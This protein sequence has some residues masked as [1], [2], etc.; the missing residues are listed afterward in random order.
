MEAVSKNNYAYFWTVT[1]VE[2]AIILKWIDLHKGHR[3][4]FFLSKKQSSCDIMVLRSRAFIYKPVAPVNL[5][6]QE[7]VLVPEQTEDVH[8]LADVHIPC[9]LS[10]FPLLA[11]ENT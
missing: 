4:I 5:S 3:E 9:C 10:L 2:M 6:A 1:I 7:R 11:F 8:A